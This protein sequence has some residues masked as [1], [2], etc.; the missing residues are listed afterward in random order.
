MISWQ[1]H[2]FMHPYVF[3]SWGTVMQEV[4]SND[5]YIPVLIISFALGFGRLRRKDSQDSDR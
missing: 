4:F 5:A 1:W 2:R 3:L